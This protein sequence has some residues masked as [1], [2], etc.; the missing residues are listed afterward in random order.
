[1]FYFTNDR[2]SVSGDIEK[3]DAKH[4]FGPSGPINAEDAKV[5]WDFGDGSIGQGVAARHSYAE[6]GDYEVKA[7]M[8][9]GNG[10]TLLANRTIHV[11]VN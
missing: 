6:L 3:F 1:M 11:G 7:K 9:L 5:E 8:T 4:V 2:D 10:Q